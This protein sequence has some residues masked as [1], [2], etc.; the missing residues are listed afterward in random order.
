MKSYTQK[1]I[2]VACAVA[3]LVFAVLADLHT[4]DEISVFPLYV[5]PLILA[6]WFLGLNWGL[7]LSLVAMLVRRWVNWVEGPTYSEEWIFWQVGLSN[8]SI[9]AFIVY[10]FHTFKRGRRA[11]RERI[12]RLESALRVCPSC[13]RVQTAN[14]PSRRIFSV[15]LKMASI[16][17][18]VNM[19]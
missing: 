1:I 14:L 13:S 12:E 7:W 15:S 17:R 11:D 16:E 8:L 3:L 18:W 5:A 6:A 9:Y 4:G 10:S 2:F 19:C